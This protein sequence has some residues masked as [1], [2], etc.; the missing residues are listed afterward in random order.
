MDKKIRYLPQVKRQLE[1][2]EQN[3][4]DDMERGMYETALENINHLYEHQYSNERI[5]GLHVSCLAYLKRWTEV[6]T[7]AEHLLFASTSAF[8][9]RYAFYYVKSLFEQGQY[10]HARDQIAEWKRKVTLSREMSE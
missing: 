5:E 2:I 1:Q 3:I 10:E 8:N 4:I 6:E 9:E 7:L